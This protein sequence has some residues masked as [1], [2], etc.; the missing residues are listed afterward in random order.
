[1]KIMSIFVFIIIL[2]IGYIIFSKINIVDTLKKLIKP[3]T[4]DLIIEEP[5]K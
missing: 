3:D 4:T 2:I 1:M 5:T